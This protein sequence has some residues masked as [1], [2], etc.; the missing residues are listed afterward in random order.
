LLL[1]R[2]YI[3]LKPVHGGKSDLGHKDIA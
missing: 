2:D 1:K 3:D